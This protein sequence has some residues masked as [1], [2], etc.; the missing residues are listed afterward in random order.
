MKSAT[1]I[2][3]WVPIILVL[4]IAG[5]NV[6]LL[7]VDL[8]AHRDRLESLLS[9]TLGRS[10]KLRGEIGFEASLIPSISLQD[11]VIGNPPWA[12]RPNFATADEITLQMALMPLFDRRI[13]IAR[14]GLRR[15]DILFERG[16]HDSNNWSFGGRS[17]TRH[18]LYTFAGL[19]ELDL[20][21]VELGYRSMQS[22]GWRVRIDTTHASWP[23]GAQLKVNANGEF[24]GRQVSLSA[25]AGTLTTLLARQPGRFPLH[26]TA[27]VDN[28]QITAKGNLTVPLNGDFSTAVSLSGDD[29]SAMG[30]LI[31][32]NLPARGPFDVSATLD[33]TGDHFHF[34]GLQANIPGQGEARS[35]RFE[36]GQ[37]ELSAEQPIEISIGGQ[38]GE[39][40]FSLKLK[41]A[42]LEKLRSDTGEWPVSIDASSGQSGLRAQGAVRLPMR[43]ARGRF[44]VDLHLADGSSLPQ[45]VSSRLKGYLPAN[46]K[47]TLH[48]S[49]ETVSLRG[50][51]LKAGATSATGTI[52]WER[53]QGTP[54]LDADLKAGTI[55]MSPLLASSQVRNPRRAGAGLLDAPLNT[56]WLRGWNS[57][58]SFTLSTLKGLAMPLHNLVFQGE[59]HE[60]RLDVATLQGTIPG[61]RI[62]LTG[63]LDVTEDTPSV[64]AAARSTAFDLGALLEALGNGKVVSGELREPEITLKGGGSSVRAL[65]TESRIDARTTTSWLSIGEGTSP[66]AIELKA[67][68]F[69]AASRPAK[70]VTASLDGTLNGVNVSSKGSIGT[71]SNWLRAGVPRKL[72]LVT[73]GRE[74]QLDLEGNLILPWTGRIDFSY[75]LSGQQLSRLGPLI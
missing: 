71:M 39:D 62:S 13:E 72:A 35:L 6:F 28:V 14:I 53:G 4:A 51:D 10:I 69:H 38:Y 40:R 5:L 8:N 68:R 59:L 1:K 60:N 63:S 24:E 45:S 47:G 57:K 7:T 26:A 32:R 46:L 56:A 37:A 61:G 17:S 75:E 42:A 43:E 33:R 25:T 18:G 58:V 48:A 64:S 49:P 20:E 22:D 44:D 9:D 2:L 27:Q 73:R 55:N 12:S 66:R 50:I 30:R 54:R 67:H 36:E 11:V 31:G 23:P 3:I 19:A 52:S 74:S 34:S 15:A 21:S 16:P 65:L 41:G 29:V 70:P